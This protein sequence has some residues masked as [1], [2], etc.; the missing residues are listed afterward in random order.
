MPN[1]PPTFQHCIRTL[2]GATPSISASWPFIA[3]TPWL[4][5][6]SVQRPEGASNLQSAARGSI[7][8]TTTRVFLRLSFETWKAFRKASATFSASPK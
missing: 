1:E 4:G 8:A 2:S 5:A 6:T 3:N 7:A